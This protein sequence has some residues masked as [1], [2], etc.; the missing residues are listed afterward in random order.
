MVDHTQL[1][2]QPCSPTARSS[3]HMSVGSFTLSLFLTTSAR[4]AASVRVCVL[5]CRPS[6]AVPHTEQPLAGPTG[7]PAT[8]SFLRS[9]S[10]R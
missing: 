3:P 10:C 7:L 9:T 4:K 1:Q 8:M 6:F 2:P 5:T